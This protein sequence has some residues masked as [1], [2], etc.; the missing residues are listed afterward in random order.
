MKKFDFI[1]YCLLVKAKRLERLAT[2]N[3]ICYLTFN[4]FLFTEKIFAHAF[5]EYA[6]FVPS[7][8]S[9]K[10]GFVLHI[11]N[12]FLDFC[13]KRVRKFQAN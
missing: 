2:L 13:V 8:E 5:F 6:A 10:A 4:Q 9:L 7:T 12:L 3:V 1:R 11:N